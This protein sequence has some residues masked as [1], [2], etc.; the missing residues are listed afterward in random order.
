MHDLAFY[1]FQ[2]ARYKEAEEISQRALG[3]SASVFGEEHLDTLEIM[4]LL[5]HILCLWGKTQE[6]EVLCRHT[7]ALSKTTFGEGSLVALRCTRIQAEIL[8]EQHRYSEAEEVRRQLLDLYTTCYGPNH[9]NTKT[10]IAKLA[11]VLHLQGKH[12]QAMVFF[13]EVYSKRPRSWDDRDWDIFL[14][15]FAGTLARLGKH[16]EAADISRQRVH[17]EDSDSDTPEMSGE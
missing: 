8:Q 15:D 1:L 2:Q 17:S 13:R 14:A 6:A 11:C 3:L 10:N 7:L 12:E 9:S 5:S 16:D 4:G